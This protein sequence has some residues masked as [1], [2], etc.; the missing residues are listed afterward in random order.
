MM[1]G[2]VNSFSGPMIG[3][4]V[5]IIIP[6]IFRDLNEYVP[7]IFAAILLIVIYLMPEGLAGLPALIIAWIKSLRQPKGPMLKKEVVKR[8]P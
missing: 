2:G 7:F 1:V 6:T 5:L 8:A 3:T 4:F